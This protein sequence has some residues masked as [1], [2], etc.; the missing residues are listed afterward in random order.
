MMNN[1]IEVRIGR[2]LAGEATSAERIAL[3]QEMASDPSL[4]QLFLEY[5]TI[6]LAKNEL[7]F[8]E[9]NTD[10][11]WNKFKEEHHEVVSIKSKNR[12]RNLSWALAAG[13][14]L[15]LGAAVFLWQNSQP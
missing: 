6:W 3:E 11:G 4:H 7:P 8:T 9:W 12:T 5:Q 10:K 2:Y 1:T 13:L 14:M 15:A